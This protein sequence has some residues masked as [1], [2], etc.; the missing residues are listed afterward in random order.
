M[1]V[2][3]RY[4]PSLLSI[5]MCNE[6]KGLKNLEPICPLCNQL[7]S[8]NFNCPYCGHPLTDQGKVSDYFDDYSPYEEINVT[9]LIASSHPLQQSGECLHMFTCSACCNYRVLAI[10]EEFVN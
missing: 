5:V 2:R 1:A 10:K 9:K 3:G 4:P 7:S 6:V 8:I